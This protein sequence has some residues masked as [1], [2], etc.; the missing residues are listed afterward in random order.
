MILDAID[1]G[2]EFSLFARII[3][4]LRFEQLA[5]QHRTQSVACGNVKSINRSPG[6][7]ETFLCDACKVRVGCGRWAPECDDKPV[8]LP[9][10]GSQQPGNGDE[11]EQCYERQT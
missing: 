4:R 2:I 1:Q 11:R 8:L 7:I 3:A 6:Q 9:G 5:G 10:F